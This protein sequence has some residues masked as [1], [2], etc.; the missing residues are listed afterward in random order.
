MDFSMAYK[1][2]RSASRPTSEDGTKIGS[3]FRYG[4]RA[5]GADFYATLAT[6]ALIFRDDRRFLLLHLKD[7]RGANIDAFFVTGA[8][9]HIHLNPPGHQASPPSLKSLSFT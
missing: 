8:L 5:G 1:K 9:V 4:D 3:G 7:T 2:R 6:Q